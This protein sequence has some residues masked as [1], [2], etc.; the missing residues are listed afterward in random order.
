MSVPS[1]NLTSIMLRDSPT[2]GN[3]CG[4]F[5]VGILISLAVSGGPAPNGA[6]PPGAATTAAAPRDTR[7]NATTAFRTNPTGFVITDSLLR[8]SGTASRNRAR[9]TLRREWLERDLLI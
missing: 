9:F 3:Q 4:R 5:A 1:A 7:T 6:E 2:L 8:P